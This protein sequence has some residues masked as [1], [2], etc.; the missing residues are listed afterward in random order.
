MKLIKLK[1]T[2]M[3]VVVMVVV[4]IVLILSREYLMEAWAREAL[5]YGGG[6]YQAEMWVDVGVL[7]V[8]M[9]MTVMVIV[10]GLVKDGWE[11]GKV[12]VFAVVAMWLAY[13]L[14]IG[15]SM[16]LMVSSIMRGHEQEVF[17]VK[18]A[19]TV[20]MTMAMVAVFI[21]KLVIQWLE[22]GLSLAAIEEGLL[23]AVS[24]MVIGSV[25]VFVVS[26]VG[27]CM[28]LMWG[29][30]LVVVLVLMLMIAGWKIFVLNK[31]LTFQKN[32]HEQEIEKNKKVN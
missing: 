29:W 9:M 26:A 2:V 19:V 18:T 28:W 1:Q 30:I 5:H 4:E 27:W 8:M 22:K 16:M 25:G 12:M 24:V 11:G 23:M 14:G 21:W 31:Y 3:T 15:G 32:K 7:G 13:I 10:C 6:W 17:I 20:V